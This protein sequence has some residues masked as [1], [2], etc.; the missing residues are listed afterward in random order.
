MDKYMMV[1]GLMIYK[2]EKVNYR[3]KKRAM[4]TMGTGLTTKNMVKD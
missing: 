3:Y 4:N 2:M 1:V